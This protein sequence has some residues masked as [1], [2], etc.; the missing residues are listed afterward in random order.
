MTSRAL[1]AVGIFG[2]IFVSLTGQCYGA[3]EVGFYKRK[4]F[5]D[6]ERV[7]AA[8]VREKFFRDPTIVAALVR[9]QF[10]DCFVNVTFLI[11]IFLLLL[12]ISFS[13]QR[14]IRSQSSGKS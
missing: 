1:V 10:H 13:R 8:V 4:C 9:M 14:S 2:L 5:V 7:V 12:Y 3:L 11:S 6:V